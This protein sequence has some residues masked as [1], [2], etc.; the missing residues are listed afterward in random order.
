MGGWS[1][2]LLRDHKKSLAEKVRR[3]KKKW[4]I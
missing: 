4:Q 3:K 1:W 2:E